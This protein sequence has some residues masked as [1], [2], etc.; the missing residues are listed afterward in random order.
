MLN[1]E[2]FSWNYNEKT[3]KIEFFSE[4]DNEGKFL[5][6][7][8]SKDYKKV[9]LYVNSEEELMSLKTIADNLGIICSVITDN[10]LTEFHG[11]PTKTCL[12]FEPLPEERINE[13]TGHLPLILNLG[14]KRK[15][16]LSEFSYY[17]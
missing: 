15:I 6:Q 9:V 11:I 12:A 8:F 5:E 16:L 3:N 14:L 17:M 1:V 2:C 10:G 7:W 4:T 13:I